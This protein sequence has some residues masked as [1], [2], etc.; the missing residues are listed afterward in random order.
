MKGL[1]KRFDRLT[2]KCYD[3]LAGVSGDAGAWDEAYETLCE[4]IHEGRRLNTGY[5][6]EL[7]LLDD[8]TDYEHD[9]C[10]WLEDYLDSLEMAERYEELRKICTELIGLF[11]WE[12]EKPSD[13]RFFIASSFR[14]EGKLDEALSFCEDWYKKE[15][16][17][18]LGAVSLIY[19]RTAVRDFKGAEQ[20]VLQYISEDGVCTDENDIVY[21]AAQ[22]LY[23]VSKNKK[24]EKWVSKAIQK[25]EEE[26]E[27]QLSGMADEGLDFNL[28]EIEDED[29]PFH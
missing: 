21:M 25:Y 1:W 14:A 13:L 4:I 27:A 11:R 22:V 18:L 5:A 8:E 26:L 6:P 7:Y 3:D 29:L 15:S 23:K 10:G 2:S 16:D 9:V 20:I 19:A 17:N 12:E 28:D 24:A